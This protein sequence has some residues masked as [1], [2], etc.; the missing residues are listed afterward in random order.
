MIGAKESIVTQ[1]TRG[2]LGHTDL[3]QALLNK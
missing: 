2:T 3:K 1:N